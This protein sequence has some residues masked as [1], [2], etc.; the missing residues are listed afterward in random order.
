MKPVVVIVGR[1]S[2]E[3]KGVRGRPFAAG[4]NYFR[5][6]ERAGGIPLMLPPI[7]GLIDD[8]PSLLERCDAVVFHGGGDIDPR[9]YGEEATEDSL[10]GIVPEH[11]AM[12]LA[13]V[14]AAIA[15]DKPVLAIC[16]GLQIL[17]V[18]LGGTLV[19]DIGSDDHWL[20][21]TT[22]QLEAGSRIAKAMGTEMPE[23][24]HCV[25]HQAL[26]RL[27]SGLR[28]VGRHSSGIIHAVELDRARWIVGTQWHPEDSAAEDPQQQGLFDELIR[29]T[30]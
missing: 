15:A 19:Q 29:Q 26:D 22:T 3:A 9:R 2:D 8:I 13:M 1:Q 4:Q 25:H 7:P 21:F 24:C 27:G 28:V 14:T 11:D 10:Y 12:E 23:R 6:V 18:A 30:S 5:S 17:N 20:R 16:R